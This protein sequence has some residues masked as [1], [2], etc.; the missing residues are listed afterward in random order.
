MSASTRALLLIPHLNG[1]GAARVSRNLTLGLARRGYQVHLAI[2]TARQFDTESL[3]GIT[4]HCLGASRVRWGLP[5]LLRLIRTLQPDLILSNMAHLNLAVLAIRPLLPRNTRLLVRND[6]GLRAERLTPPARAL[7]KMLHRR[8][9]AILCQS[10]EMASELAAQLGSHNSLRILPNPV[11]VEFV[12]IASSSESQWT[13]PG[14]HLLAIGRLVRCKGFDLLLSAFAAIAFRSP[15]AHLVILGDGAELPN[16]QQ[17]AGRLGVAHRVLFAGSTPAPEV[18]F[19]DAA[20]YIQPSREDALPNA[21]LEAAAAGLPLVAMPARG[22]MPAL[23]RGQPG[24]WV[25]PELTAP[26]LAHTIA[27]ALH[28][29]AP[30]QRFAHAWLDPFDLPKAMEHYDRAMRAVL[31]S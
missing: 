27:E 29:L 1:G 30:G 5:T 28:A 13:G 15:T 4:V 3:P 10:D 23:L 19:S 6:G 21:L 18:W 7:W 8:A 11:D 12:R 14:P 22:A 9:D 17:L 31:S 16:L 26:S 20:L 25:A 24:C 2:V